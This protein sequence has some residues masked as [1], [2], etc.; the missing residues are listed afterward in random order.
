MDTIETIEQVEPSKV[1]VPTQNRAEQEIITTQLEE[2]WLDDD[3]PTEAPPEV[4]IAADEPAT[5]I[6]AYQP[7]ASEVLIGGVAASIAFV[8]VLA[9]LSW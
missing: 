5:S 8:G 9:Y 2:V 6:F 1:G 4:W 7:S 3:T